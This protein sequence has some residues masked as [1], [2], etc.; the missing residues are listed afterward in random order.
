MSSYWKNFFFGKSI[1]LV[2]YFFLITMI[3]MTYHNHNGI[4]LIMLVLYVFC[5]ITFE[6][7]LEKDSKEIEDPKEESH[8][9][10]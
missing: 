9:V 3:W 4:A 10:S 2:G 6:L 5:D 1:S 7:D 8:R